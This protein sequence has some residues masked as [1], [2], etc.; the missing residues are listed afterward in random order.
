MRLFDEEVS[1]SLPADELAE[2][3]V[4]PVLILGCRVSCGVLRAREDA[5]PESEAGEGARKRAH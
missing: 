2:G 4:R 5:Y 3:D 1:L